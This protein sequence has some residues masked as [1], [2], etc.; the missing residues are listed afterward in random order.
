MLYVFYFYDLFN[1]LLSYWSTYRSAELYVC[2]PVH[3]YV[4]VTNL[5]TNVCEWMIFFTGDFPFLAVLKHYKYEVSF[6][7][8]GSHSAVH[9]SNGSLNCCKWY[10]CTYTHS[11]IVLTYKFHIMDTRDMKLLSLEFT[12]T[13]FY[14]QKGNF[15]CNVRFASV[16]FFFFFLIFNILLCFINYRIVTNLA[17]KQLILGRFHPFIGHE[18]PWGE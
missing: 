10:L 6:V 4:K 13:H 1:I 11:T 14:P 17:S 8:H 3:M 9:F 12:C 7:S 2:T 15:V 5:N 18:G 16:S